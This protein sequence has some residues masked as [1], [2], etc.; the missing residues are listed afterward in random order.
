M[1]VPERD[2][3]Q[4]QQTLHISF[5]FDLEVIFELLQA[6]PLEIFQVMVTLGLFEQQT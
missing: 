3:Q 6:Q 5:I 1:L 4:R 2:E